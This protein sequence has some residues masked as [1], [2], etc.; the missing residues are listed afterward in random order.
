MQIPDQKLIGS[1]QKWVDL[2]PDE[3]DKI[4]GAFEFLELEKRT[5]ILKPGEISRQI[6]FILKGVICSFFIDE[7]GV[8]HIYQIQLENGWIGDLES[9]LTQ[10]HGNFYL[11]TLEPC[12]LLQISKDRLENLYQEVPKLERYFRIL[13][14]NAYMHAL[15]RLNSTMRTTAEERYQEMVKENRDILQRVPQAYI[16]SYLGI[17]P[18]SLSRIRKKK[19]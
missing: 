10:K 14:Q 18:E 1:I 3:A 19:S 9:F 2:D 11:E 5:Q 13:F 12:L 17:T 4:H 8:E 16:A 6:F 7:K 15:Q